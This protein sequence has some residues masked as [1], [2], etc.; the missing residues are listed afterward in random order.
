[1]ISAM[2]LLSYTIFRWNIHF[3]IVCAFFLAPTYA[4]LG[5]EWL[6]AT[7]YFALHVQIA[8]YP[9]RITLIDAQERKA[10]Y[11]RVRRWLEI[12][13]LTNKSPRRWIWD[14]DTRKVFNRVEESVTRRAL[15]RPVRPLM[16]GD[17]FTECDLKTLEEVGALV[18]E[19]PLFGDF[20]LFRK[21]FHLLFVAKLC[22]AL[23]IIVFVQGV[24]Q[25]G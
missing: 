17:E 25:H 4:F 22:E 3:G 7:I 23:A 5:I 13:K 10:W 20:L 15:G 21:Y 19:I 1:M 24:V 9:R 8:A 6:R 2:A 16:D 14:R 11:L 12:N 18:E